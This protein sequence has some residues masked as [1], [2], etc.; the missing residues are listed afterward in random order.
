MKRITA[1][2][3]M[4]T[5]TNAQS[6][7]HAA[8]THTCTDAHVHMHMHMHVLI[9][10]MRAHAHGLRSHCS[11]QCKWDSPYVDVAAQ[12]QMVTPETSSDGSPIADD[13]LLDDELQVTLEALAGK[14]PCRNCELLKDKLQKWKQATQT[15]KG[16]WE[17]AKQEANK[18]REA[19]QAT[20]MWKGMY[21]EAKQEAKKAREAQE[22]AQKKVAAMEEM[23]KEIWE[24]MAPAKGPSQRAPA[25][26]PSQRAL[27]K[28]FGNAL[29]PALQKVAKPKG[30]KKKVEPPIGHPTGQKWPQPPKGKPPDYLLVKKHGAKEP[31]QSK[32]QSQG[33]KGKSKIQRAQLLP[34]PPLNPN[35]IPL[36]S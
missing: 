6:Q 24:Y 15:W 28:K 2:T 16:M 5:C 30:N 17:E 23:H 34:A 29:P 9:D 32:S 18:A 1:H 14:P 7:T 31:Q 21:E 26:G 22:A 35:L 20:H 3:H 27:A 13:E 12:F 19:Q 8:C 25:K 33:S 10:H 4:H 11:A 36:H